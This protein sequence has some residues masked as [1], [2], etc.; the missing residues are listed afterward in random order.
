MQIL[1][2]EYYFIEIY[3]YICNRIK[4]HRYD[5]GIENKKCALV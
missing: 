3:L 2:I 1:Q 5:T 4:M